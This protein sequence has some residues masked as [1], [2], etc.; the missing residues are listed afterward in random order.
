MNTHRLASLSLS[1]LA[2]LAGTAARADTNLLANGD[3][4]SFAP[5]VADGT[6][7]TISAGSTLGAWTVSGMSVDLIRNA[8]GAINNVS[9]DLAGTPGPGY[10]AQSFNAVAGTTYT[11]AW[12]YFKNGDGS[13]LTVGFGGNSTDYAAPAGVTHASLDWTASVS[14]L[15]TLTFGTAS[16]GVQGPVLDNVT[17]SAMPVPE[18]DSYALLLAGLGCMAWVARRRQAR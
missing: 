13:T 11:L 1:L 16:N 18:P 8:Y 12:D 14:G 6:Y 2:L 17:L 15:Q 9:I 3:F 4:E 7:T 10:I 5:Q